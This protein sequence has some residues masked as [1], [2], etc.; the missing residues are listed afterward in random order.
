MEVSPRTTGS[1]T[2]KYSRKNIAKTPMKD[3]MFLGQ[4]LPNANCFFLIVEYNFYDL[5]KA[6][7]S[8]KKWSVWS[9]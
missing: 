9:I 6:W 4:I 1:R 5:L 7:N 2:S 8:C 3:I